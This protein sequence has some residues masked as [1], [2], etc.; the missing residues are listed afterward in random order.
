MFYRQ[1]DISVPR[2]FSTGSVGGSG[3]LGT[4]AEVSQGHFGP[5]DQTVSFHGPNCFS[6]YEPK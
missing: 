3:L 4:G 1:P 6:P 5:K 2:H